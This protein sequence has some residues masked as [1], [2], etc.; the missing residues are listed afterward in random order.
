MA[1]KFIYE[2]EVLA[3]EEIAPHIMKMTMSAPD[4]SDVALPGQFI[5]VYPKSDKLILPRPISICDADVEEGT[6]VIVYD[7]IGAGTDE[8]SHMTR[9]DI[10]KI[11]S[12]LGNGFPAP[13]VPGAPVL[14][15]GGGVG[16]APMLF[17]AKRLAAQGSRITAV[18]GFRKDPFLTEELRHADCR[19]LVTTDMPNEHSFVGN[20]VDC[21]EI[22]QIEPGDDWTCYAC[23]PRPMLKS[24]YGYIS[25][26][27]EKTT[28]FV[29]LEEHM[30]CGYGACVGCVTDIRTGK[31][32]EGNDIIK[33]YKVCKDGPV[34]NGKAVVW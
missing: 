12:P 11:S 3:N 33:K 10:I 27:N 5:N 24:L 31:D 22:N 7:V 18:T 21:I 2:A 14:L 8:L 32:G 30:G 25:S 4:A 26:M 19:T 29:S 17:L 20:V 6:L 1:E 15:V 23:G 34:F 16:T 9:G 28:V 13:A